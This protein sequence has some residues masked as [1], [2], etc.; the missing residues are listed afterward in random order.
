VAAVPEEYRPMFI[1]VALTGV[2]LGEL[3]ALKW[4]HID[5]ENRVLHIQQSI[6]DG[7]LQTPKTEASIRAIPFGETLAAALTERMR[8]SKHIGPE[9]FIFCKTDGTSLHPDV[10][11]KDVLY[12]TLDRLGMARTKRESGFHAFRHAA[13]TLINQR[14]GDM[15]LAQKLLGHANLTTTANV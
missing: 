14:T 9:D 5:F 2:R 11:R 8:V 10:I 1:C 3:L 4:K 13:A 6:W 12:P 7:D 15:K